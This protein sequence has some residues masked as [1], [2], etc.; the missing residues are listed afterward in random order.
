MSGRRHIPWSIGI[1]P[2][3]TTEYVGVKLG[4]YYRNPELMLK[5]QLQ[6]SE[7]FHQLYGLPKKGVGPTYSSYVEASQLG[8][9]V[10]FPED[11]VPMVKGPV[12]TSAKDIYRLKILNPLQEGLMAKA[13]QT[14]KF[15]KQQAGDSIPVGLGGTEGPVTTAVIV[16]GQDFFVD[17]SLHPKEMHKLLQLVTEASFLIRRTIEKVTGEPIRSTGIADDFSGMLS[18]DQY[19]EFAFPYQKQIYEKFGLEGRSLH[20]ELLRREHLKFLPELGVTHYDPGC[21]QYLQVQDI[22]EEIPQIPFSFNLKTSQD[23]MQGTPESIRAK[24]VQAVEEGAPEMYTEICRGTH[25][26]NVRAFIKVAKQYE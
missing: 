17:I 21:D 11:N 15:M 13:I 24:Y 19:Q 4:E 8:V 25:R 10:I 23:M 1:P 2:E 9:E 26:K 22:I 5:T 3:V 20:S 7:I 12:I 18:P 14:Y 16:R 6:A